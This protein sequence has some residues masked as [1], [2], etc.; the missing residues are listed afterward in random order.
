MITF[1]NSMPIDE[2]R[3]INRFCLIRNFATWPG[4]DNFARREM[5]KILGEDKV[6]AAAAGWTR[7]ACCMMC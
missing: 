2:K 1:V 7:P 5:Y 4:F 6:G 3:S